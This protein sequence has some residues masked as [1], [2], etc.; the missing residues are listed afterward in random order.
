VGLGV[1]VEVSA[2]ANDEI[3]LSQLGFD[4]VSCASSSVNV[5]DDSDSTLFAKSPCVS[6]TW[7]TWSPKSS[8]IESVNAEIDFRCP[9]PHP[10]CVPK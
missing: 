4:G 5:W 3:L 8:I 7:V 10:Y 9:G 6:T 1:S 2:A